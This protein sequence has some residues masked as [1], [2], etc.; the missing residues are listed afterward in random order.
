MPPE[1]HPKTLLLM[2]HA[3]A[4]WPEKGVDFD[5]PLT[6]Q[7]ENAA[8]ESANWL[9]QNAFFPDFML[10][11][12]AYRTVATATILQPILKMPALEFEPTLYNAAAE[13]VLSLVRHLPETARTV[14]LLGH[15]PGI[16]AL[17]FL[18]ADRAQANFNAILPSIRDFSPACVLPLTLPGP[19]HTTRPGTAMLHSPHTPAAFNAP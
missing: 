13:T 9:A 6:S 5:R 14:L 17:A 3:H 1:I 7:G 12:A 8:R 4:D 18:L 2:R 16:P 15:N 11:S 10:V 19:W